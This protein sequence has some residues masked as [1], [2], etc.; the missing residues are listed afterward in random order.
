VTS[1]LDLV[2]KLPALQVLIF[3]GKQPGVLQSALAGKHA[4]TLISIDHP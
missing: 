4:G 2:Q 3:S 1:M